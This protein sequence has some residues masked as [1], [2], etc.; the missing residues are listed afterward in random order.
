[1]ITLTNRHLLQSRFIPT[2]RKLHGMSVFDAKTAYRIHK[3]FTQIDKPYRQCWDAFSRLGDQFGQK[4]E[5]GL[6]VLHGEGSPVQG[7]HV[8]D[9]T[10][11]EEY[12]TELNQLLDTSFDI[13]QK[14]LDANQ[15]M[16]R[17]SGE[18]IASLEPIVEG[19]ED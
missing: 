8:I 5:Q 6:P 12:E 13:P 17:F 3:I 4:D 18:E 10:K 9:E 19:L 7:Q 16:T 15:L 2:L 14:K 11:R 1:M